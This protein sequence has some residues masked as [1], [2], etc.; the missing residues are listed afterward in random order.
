M[1]SLFSKLTT[2]GKINIYLCYLVSLSRVLV[3]IKTVRNVKNQRTNVE[4]NRNDGNIVASI[5][6]ALKNQINKSYL[7]N[8]S[9]IQ[10]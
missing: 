3:R 5:K 10:A 9:L 4:I 1:V 8:Q 7:Q 2:V 6:E